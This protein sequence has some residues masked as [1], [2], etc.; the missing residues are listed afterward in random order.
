MNK[1]NLLYIFLLFFLIRDGVA[2]VTFVKNYSNGN[3]NERQPLVQTLDGGYAY[4]NNSQDGSYINKVSADG[5]LNWSKIY[6]FRAWMLTSL[7]QIPNGHFV[8]GGIIEDTTQV[9]EHN[10]Y[11]FETDSSGNPIWAKSYGDPLIVEQPM[12][13]QLTNDGGY[14][15]AGGIGSLCLIVKTNSVGDTLWTRVYSDSIEGLDCH[16]IEQTFDNCYI[17]SGRKGRGCYIMKID[18]VG[19]ILW[20]KSFS[21]DYFGTYGN[22]PYEIHQTNDSGFILGGMRDTIQGG[23]VEI[24]LIR[25]DQYGDTLWTRILNSPE[26]DVL[27]SVIQTPDEGFAFTGYAYINQG[28]VSYIGKLDLNGDTLWMKSN[29]IYQW[30]EGY[31]I[32]STTD[33]GYLCTGS[34]GMFGGVVDVFLIKTDSSANSG[35]NQGHVSF[36]VSTLQTTISTPTIYSAA[37][38][39][40]EVQT[41]NVQSLNYNILDSTICSSVSINEIGNKIFLAVSPN[42]ASSTFTI[43]GGDVQNLKLEIYNLL[44]L[45][46]YETKYMEP[47]TLNFEL[48][49][50]GIYLVRLQSEKASAVLKLIIH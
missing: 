29:S 26:R 15:L 38:S 31:S 10:F 42:P 17:L 50:K 33:G 1:K 8:G 23:D 20:I 6:P 19:Q 37:T 47:L 28:Q 43:D 32:S 18:S 4:T 34:C 44:G 9:F 27:Y 21:N 46:V 30:S 39:N 12:S 35:C 45:K 41:I 3:F 24:F 40:I 2:Q 48:F 7:I 22:F 14:I 5:N 25:T 11:L 36:N 16:F 49:P 13:M